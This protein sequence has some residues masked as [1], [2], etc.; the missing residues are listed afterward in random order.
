VLR[1]LVVLSVEDVLVM[2]PVVFATGVKED[3]VRV[4][5]VLKADV[6]R[7]LSLNVEFQ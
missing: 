7:L 2:L 4:L 3:V 5:V 6:V 1:K